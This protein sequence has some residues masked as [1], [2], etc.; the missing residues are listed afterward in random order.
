MHDTHG[1]LDM[2]LESDKVIN[3]FEGE[4]KFNKDNIAK[5]VNKYLKDHTFFIQAGVDSHNLLQCQKA[6]FNI[7]KVYF[8]AGSHPE[9]VDENFNLAKYLKYQEDNISQYLDNPKKHR[10]VG[11]GEI[12]LDYYW[13][14]DEVVQ[15]KQKDLFESQIQLAIRH[16][17][18]IQLH[19][20]DAFDDAFEILKKYPKIHGKFMVHCFTGNNKDLQQILDMKGLVAYGGVSTFKNSLEL[21]ETIKNCPIESFV[22]ETDLPYLAPQAVR[23]KICIPEHI[24]HTA[25]HHAEKRCLTLP[26]IWEISEKNAKKF[27]N[28]E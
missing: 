19:I 28:I 4:R 23:G 14:K 2:L 12:G 27:F 20:R 6:F 26:Q 9:I 21:Q 22:F 8:L 18:P 15:K 5:H 17:L 13:A 10:I 3:D 25:S 24:N 16:D 11:I 7:P 1:H